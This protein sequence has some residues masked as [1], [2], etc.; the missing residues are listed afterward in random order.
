MKRTGKGTGSN[1]VRELLESTAGAAEMLWP[2]PKPFARRT[3]SDLNAT[4]KFIER[5]AAPPAT[6]FLIGGDFG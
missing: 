2:V 3:F 6:L 4:E 5:P 1:T